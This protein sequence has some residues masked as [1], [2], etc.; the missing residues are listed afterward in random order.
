MIFPKTKQEITEAVLKVLPQD[1]YNQ[2]LDKIM[3]DWWLTGRGGQ[4]LRLSA[5]GLR[6]FKEAK[7][8]YYE[9]PLGPLTE[10][11]NIIAPESF[12]SELIKKINCPYYLGV[13]KVT[14]KHINP[15]IIRVYDHKIAMLISLY[16]TLRD[17]L[18]ANIV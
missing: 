10:R 1:Q 18:D 14:D 17:Y 13:K 2:P 4:G 3:F 8:E 11:K 15:G 12:I 16:G 6:A 7:I 5:N 9:F